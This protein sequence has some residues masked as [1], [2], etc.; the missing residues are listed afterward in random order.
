MMASEASTP[1]NAILRIANGVGRNRT[2]AHCLTSAVERHVGC[3]AA[4]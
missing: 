3:A 1:A 4:G 2:P